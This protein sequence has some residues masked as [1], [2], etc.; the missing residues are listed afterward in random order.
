MLKKTAC[1][2]G[3]MLPGFGIGALIPLVAGLLQC[4]GQDESA[5]LLADTT[6]PELP[7]TRTCVPPAG[8]SAAP[9]SLSTAL[10]LVNS[11]PHPVSIP[12]FLESL[13]R[14]L[15]LNATASAFSAQPAVGKRSPRIFLFSGRLIISVVPAGIGV[16]MLE[17]SEL[18]SPTRSIKAELQFPVTQVVDLP[19]AF[20]RLPFST[21]STCGLCHANESRVTLEGTPGAY[22][23]VALRP[24]SDT[25]V[26]LEDVRLEFADCD[27]EK[28]HERCA[29]LAA[30]FAHGKVNSWDFPSEMATFF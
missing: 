29:I 26:E 22:E 10:T 11:L 27:A 19:A 9:D 1:R 28:E 8:V 25:Q 23:S 21:I 16:D 13:D 3:K 7:D 15:A 6:A 12:C 20:A 30:L 18:T 14:P 4:A 17:F 2:V 24:R 5:L